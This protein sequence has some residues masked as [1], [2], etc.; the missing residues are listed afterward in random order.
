MKKRSAP[1]PET[2]FY[3]FVQIAN[4]SNILLLDRQAIG[5]AN[6]IQSAFIIVLDTDIPK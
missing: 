6:R 5:S 1:I 3:P 4:P 2:L